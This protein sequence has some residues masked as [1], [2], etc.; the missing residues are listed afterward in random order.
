M[1]DLHINKSKQNH[2]EQINWTHNYSCHQFNI[3]IKDV[4]EQIVNNI[5]VCIINDASPSILSSKRSCNRWN[6]QHKIYR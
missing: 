4:F 1:L 6:K 2:T 5:S 3:Y